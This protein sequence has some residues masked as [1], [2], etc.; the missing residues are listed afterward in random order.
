MGTYEELDRLLIEKELE[1]NRSATTL[2]QTGQATA[3]NTIWDGIMCWPAASAG[4]LL[5][6]PCAKYVA[7]FNSQVTQ[8]IIISKLKKNLT[9]FEKRHIKNCFFSI[10]TFIW[11]FLAIILSLFLHFDCISFSF[12]N[13]DPSWIISAGDSIFC[14]A[15]VPCLAFLFES[16][17]LDWEKEE[18]LKIDDKRQGKV[19][20]FW[21]GHYVWSYWYNSD[22]ILLLTTSL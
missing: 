14:N 3:C 19:K 16:Q 4:E 8:F 10:L 2:Q 11:R 13:S 15:L 7:G 21:W 22:V 20:T 9:V 6:Q 17:I 5:T 12:G 1:C 18:D